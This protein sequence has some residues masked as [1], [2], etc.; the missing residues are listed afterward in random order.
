MI[1]FKV[2]RIRF[3]IQNIDRH[4]KDEHNC[5]HRACHVCGKQFSSQVGFDYHIENTHGNGSFPCENCGEIYKTK[6]LEDHGN[7][8]HLEKTFVCDKCG[9]KCHNKFSVKRHKKCHG[10]ECPF[11]CNLCDKK[12]RDKDQLKEHM[13]KHNGE[14]PYRCK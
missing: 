5:G 4:R 8:K 7:R 10:Q 2:S 1:R 12:C 3:C 9:A 11:P 13:F 6:A 14:R